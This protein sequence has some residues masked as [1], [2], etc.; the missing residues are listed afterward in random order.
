MRTRILDIIRAVITAAVL[1]VAAYAA[2]YVRGDQH[3]FERGRS[4][5]FESILKHYPAT[6]AHAL[7]CARVAVGLE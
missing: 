3:G 4:A 1:L 7:E 5:A 2:S 6:D